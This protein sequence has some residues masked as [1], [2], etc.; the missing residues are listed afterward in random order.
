M[1]QQVKSL[2]SRC[3]DLSSHPQNRVKMGSVMCACDSNAC[4]D[5]YPAILAYEDLETRDLVLNKFEDKD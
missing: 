5:Q 1:A 2:A 4:T 3:G